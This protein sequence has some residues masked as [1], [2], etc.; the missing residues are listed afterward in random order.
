MLASLVDHGDG[1]YTATY[2]SRFS[3]DYRLAVTL[4]GEHLLGSPFAVVVVPGAC[5]G[6]HSVAEGTGLANATARV[7]VEFYIHARDE[8]ATKIP[9]GGEKFVVRWDGEGER[10]EG[11]ATDLGDGTY[12]VK[13]KVQHAGWY[14]MAVLH[15]GKHIKGSPFAVQV[16]DSRRPIH[17]R[18]IV[19][20]FLLIFFGQ[21]SMTSG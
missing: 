20:L 2:K 9:W 6:T 14:T 4:G 16:P 10:M 13:Y 19:L 18:L 15:H 8:D 3:G 11:V 1:S 5:S 7:P 12:G 21:W 17:T